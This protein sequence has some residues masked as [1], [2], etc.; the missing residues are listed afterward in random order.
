MELTNLIYKVPAL[1]LAISIHEYAHA[2]TAKAFGDLSA[3]L[4]GRATLNPLRHLDPLGTICL[5]FFSFGWARPV[6]INPDNFHNRTLGLFL[7]LL[8]RTLI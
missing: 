5:L 2:R 7:G 1:L 8:G 4:L 6:P 3:F